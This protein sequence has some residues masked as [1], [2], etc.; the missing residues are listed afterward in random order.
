MNAFTCLAIIYV[1]VCCTSIE[2][3]SYTDIISAY[4]KITE[5][6]GR[7]LRSF[8]ISGK[9]ASENNSLLRIIKDALISGGSRVF[10]TKIFPGSYQTGYQEFD[11]ILSQIGETSRLSDPDELVSS[12]ERNAQR[13]YPSTIVVMIENL[14]EGS[15]Q[16]RALFIR[17]AA[18]QSRGSFILVGTVVN[19]T[20][21]WKD[22][23]LFR[24]LVSKEPK[25]DLLELREI[26]IDDATF[27]IRSLGYDLPMEFI[28]DVFE[29][30]SGNLWLIERTLQYYSE[31]GI[32]NRSKSIDWA[33]F[34]FLP[35]PGSVEEYY[36]ST[37]SSLSDSELLVLDCLSMESGSIGLETLEVL[38]PAKD[39][40]TP[41]A[42]EELKTKKIVDIVFGEVKF[43]ST[44]FYRHFLKNRAE[45]FPENVLFEVRSHKLF[46]KLPLHLKLISLLL[47][48]DTK[49]VSGIVRNMG[50]SIVKSFHSLDQLDR[51][52]DLAKDYIQDSRVIG[53]LQLIRSTHLYYLGYAAKAI[54][55]L[56]LALEDPEYS[57]QRNILLG[58]IYNL[59]GEYSKSETMAQDVLK[60]PKITVRNRLDAI[61][62]LSEVY[63]NRGEGEKSMDLA[64]SLLE[65]SEKNNF[66]DLSGKALTLMGNNYLMVGDQE[67]A[68]ESYDRSM[69]VS[70]E[71]GLKTQLMYNIINKGLILDSRGQYNEEI[72][73][74]I[75]ALRISYS[76]GDMAVRSFAVSSLADVQYNLGRINEAK[77]YLRTEAE[78][79]RITGNL[80]MQLYYMRAVAVTSLL[81]L[82]FVGLE[83][84]LNDGA[85][86]AM[87]L[88]VDEASK[89]MA[90][91]QS[92]IRAFRGDLPNG[93]G[94]S[95]FLDK[96]NPGESFLPYFYMIGALAFLA[97]G[98]R[99][100]S[101]RCLSNFEESA[102]NYSDHFYEGWAAAARLVS[103]IISNEMGNIGADASKFA[104][105]FSDFPFVDALINS[106]K[107]VVEHHSSSDLTT[108]VILKINSACQNSI[109]KALNGL[110]RVVQAKLISY[111]FQVDPSTVYTK[112]S[113]EDGVDE[114][115]S[116]IYETVI[117]D[118]AQSPKKA[119]V[120]R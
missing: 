8:V 61:S 27:L 97:V 91:F 39:Y 104:G 75:D 15:D 103:A 112:L 70:E 55:G 100:D 95:H 72:S 46:D 51:F 116:R 50:M 26:S 99:D 83:N 31:I 22:Y 23:E 37:F 85:D 38:L 120:A 7:D 53:Q 84:S 29:M 80:P 14:E 40:G 52:I 20:G 105:K 78:L 92:V 16:S 30:C 111:Q 56:G 86:L 94:L 59:Q 49:E 107:Q 3:I 21:G 73:G 117:A 47:N 82:D 57:I 74:Y 76:I 28:V 118:G 96:L 119:S 42:L 45:S 108:L 64:K 43:V 41:K 114:L 18:L 109:P 115:M 25:I 65:E 79:L 101:V 110:L 34:R 1:A 10:H 90:S 32:I 93:I 62:I 13:G 24:T 63:L 106:V 102:S 77:S 4:R 68:I 58:Y 81:D 66:Y 33:V 113:G 36:Q 67:K 11:D 5:A 35:I 88:N 71:H 87:K 98:N 19:S 6:P 44:S 17:L 89:V 9:D 48:G 60:R 69:V 2:L 54:E 12:F